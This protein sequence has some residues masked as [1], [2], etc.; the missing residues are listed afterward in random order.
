[1]CQLACCVPVSG[2]AVVCVTPSCQSSGC[3]R[4][5]CPTLVLRPVPCGTPNCSCKSP[6]A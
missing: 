4:P 5:S 1:S 6:G 3:C 2:K